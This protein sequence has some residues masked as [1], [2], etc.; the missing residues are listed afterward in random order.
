MAG[1]I[2]QPMLLESLGG[3]SSEAAR[4]VRCLKKA[5]AVNTDSAEAK[6]ATMFWQRLSID[7]QRSVHR[8][9]ARRVRQPGC[10]DGGHGSAALRLGALFH[11]PEDRTLDAPTNRRLM[12]LASVSRAGLTRL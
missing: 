7:L 2:F 4:V 3:V 5:V 1:V 11:M 12:L 8:A 6:I 10:G 9:F